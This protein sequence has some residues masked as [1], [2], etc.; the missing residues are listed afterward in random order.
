MKAAK[1]VLVLVGSLILWAGQ[2]AMGGPFIAASNATSE[3]KDAAIYICDGVNDEV[4]LQQVFDLI[5]AQG[6]GKV[7][8]SS[9]DFRVANTVFLPRTVTIEGTGIYGTTIRNVSTSNQDTFVYDPYHYRDKAGG[10]FINLSRFNFTSTVRNTGAHLRLGYA[11][12]THITD[13][14]FCGGASSASSCMANGLV[15]YNQWGM[16]I[17]RSLVEWCTGDGWVF[18]GPGNIFAGTFSNFDPNIHVGA[19]VRQGN[20]NVGEV[21]WIDNDN[22]GNFDREWGASYLAADTGADPNELGVIPLTGSFSANVGDITF[23]GFATTFTPTSKSPAISNIGPKITQC[24]IQQNAG[25]SLVLRGNCSKAIIMASELQ[26][27]SGKCGISFEGA[28]GT[29]I[30]GNRFTAIAS[31]SNSYIHF[32]QPTSGLGASQKNLISNNSFAM[33]YATIPLVRMDKYSSSSFTSSNVVTDNLAEVSSSDVTAFIDEGDPYNRVGYNTFVGNKFEDSRNYVDYSNRFNEVVMPNSATTFYSAL[34]ASGNMYVNTDD[35]AHKQRRLPLARRG[36]KM[37]FR[38][39]N[40]NGID[41][42]P[43]TSPAN[44]IVWDSAD[45]GV[46][47]ST[48]SIYSNEPDATIFLEC[49]TDTVWT[50]TAAY[51][52]WVEQDD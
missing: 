3:E 6:G 42:E 30:T 29:L 48:E 14:F 9:G 21:T 15:S 51:G 25:N 46:V 8:L 2:F 35:T 22:S 50:V 52:T 26:A 40:T 31:N 45:D 19:K 17:D 18:S 27:S 34:A 38:V 43:A 37:G 28:D 16:N 23:D 32:P 12:D 44:T 4:E 36:L 7:E 1:V 33:S 20:D 11:L 49:F 10:A 39:S 13:V 24:K 41:I 5:E 47:T